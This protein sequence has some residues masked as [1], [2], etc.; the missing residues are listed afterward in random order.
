[1]TDKDK[2][3]NDVC[4]IDSSKI[5]VVDQIKFDEFKLMLEKLEKT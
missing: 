3:G 5:K 4:E 2:S 1:M